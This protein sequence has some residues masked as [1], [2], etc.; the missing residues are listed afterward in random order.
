MWPRVGTLPPPSSS[1]YERT[2]LGLACRKDL[3]V[4]PIFLRISPLNPEQLSK[5][6]SAW[7]RTQSS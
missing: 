6:D 1:M 3:Y 5:M 2:G 4:D 7:T